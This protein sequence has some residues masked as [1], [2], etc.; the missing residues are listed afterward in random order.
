MEEAWAAGPQAHVLNTMLIYLLSI[1]FSSK[2]GMKRLE[3]MFANLLWG[4]IEDRKKDH[5]VAGIKFV[6]QSERVS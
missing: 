6:V 3:Q 1:M 2:E 4:E 5:Q